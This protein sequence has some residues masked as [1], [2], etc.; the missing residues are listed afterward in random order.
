MDPLIE[1]DAL[2]SGFLPFLV[3]FPGLG[4]PGITCMGQSLSHSVCTNLF[5]SPGVEEPRPQVPW[6]PL[7]AVFSGQVCSQ[8]RVHIFS[9]VGLL[10]GCLDPRGP[11]LWNFMPLFCCLPTIPLLVLV[12]PVPALVWRLLPRG[13]LEKGTIWV[14]VVNL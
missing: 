3:L 7:Y 5:S 2:C 9:L 4:L 13:V 14:P 6:E 11:A 10:L 1:A 8:G 12:R